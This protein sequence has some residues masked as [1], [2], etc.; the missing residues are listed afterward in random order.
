MMKPMA[1]DYLN[2]PF[3]QRPAQVLGTAVSL[4]VPRDLECPTRANGLDPF[5]VAGLIR[6]ES[7]FNPAGAF[8]RQC[9]RA[10]AGACRPPGGISRK[11]RASCASPTARLFQPA[12]NLRIGTTMLRSMLD[13]NGGNLEQ[14]L[15]SYN[16][17]PNRVAEWSL[18]RLPRAGGVCGIDPVHRDPRIRAGRAAQRGYLPAALPVSGGINVLLSR[19]NPFTRSWSW[20][21]MRR[22]AARRSSS[23]P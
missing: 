9:L 23:V 4:A 13:R 21:R 14:T 8:A 1:P 11:A 15:A 7:E 6:Q 3:D 17:G 10:D 16:A 2:L 19:K 5:L 22:K 18:G 12:T 20:S